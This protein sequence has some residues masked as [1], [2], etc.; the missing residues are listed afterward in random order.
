MTEQLHFPFS[1]SHTGEGNGNP[2]QCSCL[3]NPRDGGAWWAAV[4]GVTKS[5]TR[6]KWLSSSSNRHISPP[7]EP[8]THHPNA[9]FIVKSTWAMKLH[10]HV[11]DPVDCSSPGSVHRIL[12]ARILEWVTILFSRGS[13]S[14]R[15][16][17]WVS[18]I[19]SGLFTIWASKRKDFVA[20]CPDI[21]PISYPNPYFLCFCNSVSPVT[22]APNKYPVCTQGMEGAAEGWFSDALATLMSPSPLRAMSVSPILFAPLLAINAESS[23][24]NPVIK[25]SAIKMINWFLLQ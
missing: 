19:A 12:Q 13:S 3:E 17:T 1:L 2:L 25:L 15:E 20:F 10:S 23:V 6:L 7:P 24:P 14:S 21:T 4:C 9:F 18:C 22:W 8:S 11:W 5:W 16:R